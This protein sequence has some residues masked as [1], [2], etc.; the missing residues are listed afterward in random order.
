MTHCT[1]VTSVWRSCSIDGSATES[2]VKSLATTR[3]ATP[4]AIMPRIVDLLRRASIADMVPLCSCPAA[5]SHKGQ[6]KTIATCLIVSDGS[7][8]K[9][10]T[11]V[12]CELLK[13]V[14]NS[15]GL[16]VANLVLR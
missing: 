16:R 12:A 7:I 4:M 5:V 9:A 1:V 6:K 2:A 15:L 3:T 8:S 10:E 11:D 13:Q 14:R